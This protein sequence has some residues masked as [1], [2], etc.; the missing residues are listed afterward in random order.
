MEQ[1]NQLIETYGTHPGVRFLT[2][3]F[4]TFVLAL[5]LKYFINGLLKLLTRKTATDLDDRIFQILGGPVFL[6]VLFSGLGYALLDLDPGQHELF[7]A[8]GVLKTLAVL[9]WGIAIMRLAQLLLS[10]L[11]NVSDRATFIQPSTLPLFQILVK[12]IVV[13][14]IAYF[15]LVAW[16]IDVTGWLASAGIVGIAV[17]FAAKDTLANLF[18]GLFIVT[19]RPYKIGDFIILEKGNERG[20]V[21]QIGLRSTRILTRDDI[22]VT[23]PMLSLA[24]ARL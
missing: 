22:E 9:I 1:L 3:L 10:I 11:S 4:A 15:A 8:M 24:I 20:K 13:G 17:G 14:G 23:I 7:V 5:F 16:N 2:I 19:D 21:T 6:S 18:A 12:T